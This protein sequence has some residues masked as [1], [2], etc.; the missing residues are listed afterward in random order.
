MHDPGHGLVEVTHDRGHGSCPGRFR[1]PHP[2]RGGG[3]GGRGQRAA[4]VPMGGGVQRQAT[5]GSTVSEG[6]RRPSAEGPRPS[7]GG[8]G[9]ADPRPPAGPEGK[10][11]PHHRAPALTARPGPRGRRRTVRSKRPCHR[12]SAL[13]PLRCDRSRGSAVAGV[14][15]PPA[16]YK[17]RKST[18]L[19][20]PLRLLYL[21]HKQW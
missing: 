6:V 20:R 18:K 10:R 7:G 8:L 11:D 13:R 14:T 17:L 21:G 9:A 19:T 5:W 12:R 1:Y 16:S 4:R 2:S 3:G 15:P